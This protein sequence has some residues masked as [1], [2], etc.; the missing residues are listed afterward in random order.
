MYDMVLVR[1]VLPVSLQGTLHAYMLRW[2][3]YGSVVGRSGE[4]KFLV[5]TAVAAAFRHFTS[6]FLVSIFFS[7]SVYLSCFTAILFPL[8]K[9]L[10]AYKKVSS[11]LH[12]SA[13]FESSIQKVFV[14]VCVFVR[15]RVECL[16]VAIVHRVGGEFLDVL[17]FFVSEG[18]SCLFAPF[19]YHSLSFLVFSVIVGHCLTIYVRSNFHDN[20]KNNCNNSKNNDN[21]VSLVTTTHTAYFCRF[22]LLNGF[23][24]RSQ[25]T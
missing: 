9:C 18:R 17:L 2:W 1:S 10:N 21:R 12:S 22:R 16:L 8:Y 5:A 3:S 7:F 11:V 20:N 14:C 24:A 25:T 4:K 23:H 19:F 15:E 13:Y 6:L